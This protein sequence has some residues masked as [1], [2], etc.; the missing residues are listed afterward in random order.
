[1]DST[2][3]LALVVAAVA[4]SVAGVSPP[5]LA[6]QRP[7]GQ[8]VLDTAC[9]SAAGRLKSASYRQVLVL[10][11]VGLGLEECLLGLGS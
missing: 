11:P 1:M 5:G 10:N 7:I 6:D 2:V 8:M 9:S 3:Q 4:G